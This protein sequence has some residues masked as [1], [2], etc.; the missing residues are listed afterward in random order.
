[1]S[2][3]APRRRRVPLPS[4]PRPTSDVDAAALALSVL[5]RAATPLTRSQTAGATTAVDTRRARHRERGAVR[6]RG[7]RRAPARSKCPAGQ[8]S[9]GTL[10]RKQGRLIRQAALDETEALRASALHN[11]GPPALGFVRELRL[12]AITSMQRATRPRSTWLIRSVRVCCKSAA[13]VT[14]RSSAPRDHPEDETTGEL[15]ATLNPDLRRLRRAER[16]RRIQAVIT[17]LNEELDALRA[18]SAHDRTAAAHTV[19]VGRSRH[20]DGPDRAAQPAGR[21]ARLANPP[22]AAACRR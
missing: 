21:R 4:S 6:G 19:R 7:R 12:Q 13:D 22:A 2:A 15:T 18:S 3:R 10:V 16:K 5:Q 1:M 14:G 17:R 9:E 8:S 11:L 20:A